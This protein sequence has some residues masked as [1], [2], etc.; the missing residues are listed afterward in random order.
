MCAFAFILSNLSLF[1]SHLGVLYLFLGF[2]CVAVSEDGTL[3]YGALNSGKGES[4]QIL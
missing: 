1:F 2:A 3:D 4:Y